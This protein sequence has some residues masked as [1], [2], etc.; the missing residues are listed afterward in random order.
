MF[1]KSPWRW[2]E[3]WG[4]NK[5]QCATRTDLS[6]PG[7]D[8]EKLDGLARCAWARPGGMPT[9]DRARFAAHPHQP[10]PTRHPD[11]APH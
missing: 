8:L 5:E 7:A 3:L 10:L 4:M 2:P 6:R 9:R 11:P 1:L